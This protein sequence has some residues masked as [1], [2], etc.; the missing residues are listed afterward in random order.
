MTS[1]KKVRIQTELDEV[2]SKIITVANQISALEEQHHKL[3]ERSI[4]L[5]RQQEAQLSFTF[6]KE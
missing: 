6:E 1:T 3:C 5:R 4:M 2:E